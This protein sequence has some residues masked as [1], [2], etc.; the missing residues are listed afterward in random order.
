MHLQ[1]STRIRYLIRMYTNVSIIAERRPQG[2]SYS[3]WMWNPN[4]R[5]LRP[6]IF[7]NPDNFHSM[8]THA[9]D[10]HPEVLVAVELL[11]F[12]ELESYELSFGSYR[13]SR[14]VVVHETIRHRAFF[15]VIRLWIF[16]AT[17]FGFGQL[18]LHIIAINRIDHWHFGDLWRTLTKIIA[19]IIA[20]TLQ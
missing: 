7:G 18:W 5:R 2:L 3:C 17:Q 6:E 14:I 8:I 11:P 10:S 16:M 13:C 19:V 1:Q 12:T 20:F 9:S 4:S 15:T